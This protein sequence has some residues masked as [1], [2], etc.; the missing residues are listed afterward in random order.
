MNIQSHLPVMNRI[1]EWKAADWDQ[2]WMK[3]ALALALRGRGLCGPNPLVGAVLVYPRGGDRSRFETVVDPGRCDDYFEVLGEGWHVAYGLRHAEVMAIEAARD[4][5]YSSEILAGAT[6]YCNLEPCSFSDG[7]KHQPPCS[8]RIIREKLH[9]VV[10]GNRDPNPK[11]DGLT[12]LREHDVTVRE[13][14]LSELGATVN[15]GF[16][17]WVLRSQPWVM[18]KLAHS[19]DGCIATKTGHSQWIT[20]PTAR[21]CVQDLRWGAC[22]VMVG[23]GTIAADDPSLLVREPFLSDITRSIWHQQSFDIGAADDIGAAEKVFRRVVWDTHLS[24]AEDERAGRNYQVFHDQQAGA[25]IVVH[26]ASAP[27]S[28]LDFLLRN[29]I[30]SLP[31][32]ELEDGR[33]ALESSLQLLSGRFGLQYLLLE[34]GA[35]LAT[36][37]LRAGLVDEWYGFQA[38]LFLGASGY[39]IGD[40][41][42]EHKEVNLSDALRLRQVSYQV[43]KSENF[44]WGPPDLLT[45]G[46]CT[47]LL[48]G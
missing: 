32:S 35:D 37:F 1:L 9:R 33:P 44:D 31:V 41:F 47:D 26:S 24:L 11:V 34:G 13:G 5:G 30:Q 40:L 4:R 15:Q 45:H 6:L 38:P 27:E 28:R 7:T 29:G 3:R 12:E 19:L 21:R 25:S 18:L 8:G 42:P 20:G 14:V 10:I 36:R 23:K 39:R 17:S 46:Y 43:L 48:G 2:F 22:A 16:F